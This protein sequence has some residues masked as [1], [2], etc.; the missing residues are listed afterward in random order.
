M[1]DYREL[2]GYLHSRDRLRLDGLWRRY[3]DATD[4]IDRADL[5]TLIEQTVALAVTQS[6][7][8][9]LAELHDKARRA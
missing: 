8:T 4:I 3:N 2:T 1:P 7:K 9:Q 5:A 6:L